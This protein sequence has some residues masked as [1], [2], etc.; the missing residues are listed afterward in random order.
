MISITLAE[1]LVLMKD[2]EAIGRSVADF[3]SDNVE[4]GAI[5]R[6]RS[7]VFDE[8]LFK[9]LA[10]LNLFG[11]TADIKYGG[12][13]ANPGITVRVIEEIAK[14]D[15]ALA[16]SYLAHEI[17]FVH[18]LAAYGTEEQKRVYLPKVISGEW[19]AGG[20]MTTPEAGSDVLSMKSR[21]LLDGDKWRINGNYITITNYDG[22]VLLVYS[23]TSDERRNMSLFIV[24]RGFPGFSA[25]TGERYKHGMHASPTG[26][27]DL[28][29]CMVPYENI[30]GQEGLAFESMMRNLEFER[31]GL[32][33]I[34]IGAAE[35]SLYEAMRHANIRKIRDTLLIDKDITRQKIGESVSEIEVVRRA[36]YDV[37]RQIDPNVRNSL[38]ANSVKLMAERVGVQITDR[39]FQIMAGIGY[40]GSVP[41]RM[42]RDARLIKIG[43]GATETEQLSIANEV[44]KRFR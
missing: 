26:G 12:M 20:A 14:S 34:S 22:N 9:K 11:I 3:V 16:L 31:V 2:E 4:P 10:E 27:L 17:M 21:A 25:G 18:N 32:A 24:E 30:V 37:A 23:K 13:G 19:R 6:D 1:K 43:G 8:L 38:G 7:S 28:E 40:C 39:A 35:R 33:A 41:E 42:Y 29:N 36:M 44:I 5:S 15:P